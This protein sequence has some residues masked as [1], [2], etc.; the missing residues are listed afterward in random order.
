MA[1]IYLFADETGDPSFEN[2][3]G[4][5]RYFGFGTA[6]FTDLHAHAL[7]QGFSLRCDLERRGVILPG[8]FHAKNDTNATRNEV[9]Q[10][11]TLQAPRFDFTMLDKQKAYP[12]VKAQGPSR[13]YKLAWYLHF[14]QVAQLVSQPGDV[15]YAISATIM[16]NNK[17]RDVRAALKDVAD[18][19][20]NRTIIPIMWDSKTSW[21]LQVADYGLWAFQKKVISGS[22]PWWDS[23][24]QPT[25]GTKFFPW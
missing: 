8:G 13:L 17:K 7:W 5:S 11:V 1:N 14:K 21:G 22:C 18:Q 9:F 23:A 24:V 12:H 20:G 2:S 3:T 10:L 25:T 4:V 15:L 19:I 16:T 6:V